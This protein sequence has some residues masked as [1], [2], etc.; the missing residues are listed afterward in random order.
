MFQS[1]LLIRKKSVSMKPPEAEER[2][3]NR[4]QVRIVA[5]IILKDNESRSAF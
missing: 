1:I 5:F 3:G 4:E 2:P